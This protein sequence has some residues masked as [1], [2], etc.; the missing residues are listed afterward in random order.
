MPFYTSA[1]KAAHYRNAARVALN[2][3]DYDKAQLYYR[4]ITQLKGPDEA[5]RYQV[6]VTL[7]KDGRW[8]DA[9][10]QMKELATFD[11]GSLPVAHLWIADAAMRDKL[12][13]SDEQ[14]LQILQ[15]HLD[16]LHERFPQD[17]NIA[18]MRARM[19]RRLGN[20]DLSEKE[21]R[22]FED[23]DMAIQVQLANIKAS[24]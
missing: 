8:V 2:V 19:F 12:E 24:K 15:R 17:V 18:Y 3:K 5:G 16:H 14:N 23:A 20:D 6:A 9:Y 22:R 10:R 1:A 13:L 4:K 21:L 7:A 11:P